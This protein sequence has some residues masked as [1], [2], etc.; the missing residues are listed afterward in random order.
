MLFPVYLSKRVFFFF[1]RHIYVNAIF[2]DKHGME[3]MP[4]RYNII[5][6][7]APVNNAE[8]LNRIM[9]Y[10]LGFPRAL[11]NILALT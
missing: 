6:D 11:A 1:L 3:R 2:H 9:V 10:L 7:V 5:V 4:T 8:N